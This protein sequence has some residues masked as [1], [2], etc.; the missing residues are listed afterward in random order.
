MYNK[1]MKPVK[2]E[3][4]LEKSLNKEKMGKLF[5]ML[6]AGIPQTIA[7]ATAGV[8]YKKWLEFRDAYPERVEQAILEMKGQKLDEVLEDLDNHSPKDVRA[9]AL[10]AKL[11][12]R[13]DD[14]AK[15]E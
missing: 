6:A 14:D 8:D 11:Y 10:K 3:L 9:T 2:Q 4:W 13:Y 5:R 7:T 1:G 15:P 12:S